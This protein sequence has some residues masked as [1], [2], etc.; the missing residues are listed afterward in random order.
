MSRTVIFDAAITCLRTCNS[1]KDG[2]NPDTND[3]GSCARRSA[4][5]IN[6]ILFRA[7]T[8]RTSSEMTQIQGPGLPLLQG[9]KTSNCLVRPLT[10]S[11]CVQGQTHGHDG[12]A[13]RQTAAV[14]LS[15]GRHDEFNSSSGVLTKPRQRKPRTMPP[16]PHLVRR[17]H[18]IC[19]SPT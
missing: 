4:S 17:E 6:E 5:R 14:F 3:D 1:V 19:R 15:F 11:L 8:Y 18:R 13:P 10:T 2:Q 12:L 7:C 9:P 16:P